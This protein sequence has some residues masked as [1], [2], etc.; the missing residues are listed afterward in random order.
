MSLQNIIV[1][2]EILSIGY[3]VLAVY[4]R[5][6]NKI[7]YIHKFPPIVGA[8]AVP[9]LITTSDLSI[10]DSDKTL[11]K[12]TLVNFWSSTNLYQ[13]NGDWKGGEW[14]SNN[15]PT[16]DTTWCTGYFIGDLVVIKIIKEGIIPYS[17]RKS[18]SFVD[19]DEI[20]NDS[21]NTAWSCNI[22]IESGQYDN[23]DSNNIYSGY[24][25]DQPM[26]QKAID[27]LFV[28][29]NIEGKRFVKILRRGNPHPNV[30]MPKLQMPGAGEHREPG[31]KITFKNEVLRAIEEEI[32]IENDTLTNSYL[33]QIGTY[34]S[35]K[36][37]PRYWKF[38]AKQDGKSIQFGIERK[39]STDLYVLYLESNSNIEPFESEP[40][41]TIEINS[42]RWV[43]LESPILSNKEIWLV[44]EHSSYFSKTIYILNMFDEL[45]IEHKLSKK[46]I[47]N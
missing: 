15:L 36:R 5:I 10:Y 13:D 16:T 39:S 6:Y 27:V 29:K 34:N 12:E 38:S 32:G 24:I 25:C 1:K 26:G 3:N 14:G 22:Q 35:D 30:D 47:L 9:D 46:I 4:L 45:S 21:E 44:P 42:K 43:N 8:E 2:G 17:T 18:K 23:I 11:K 20:I 33:L 40:S 28:W 7:I 37:D 41:D 31:N 19:S